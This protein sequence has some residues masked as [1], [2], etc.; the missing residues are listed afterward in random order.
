MEVYLILHVWLN[1][2]VVMVDL[3]VTTTFTGPHGKATTHDEVIHTNKKHPFFTIEYG[4]LPVGKITVGMHMLRA[5][6]QVG[7]VTGW[8]VVP[9]TK[10][11]YN[12]EVQQDHTF[13]VGVGQWVVHNKCGPEDYQKLRDNLA[14]TGRTVDDGQQ[15]HHI[16]PCEFRNH[17]L[18]DAT[19][20]RAGRAFDINAE[21]NDRPLWDYNNR[22]TAAN[23]GE[24][25]HA[26]H[27]AYNQMARGMLNDELTSLQT[28][29]TLS[30]DTA[31]GSLM[32]IIDSLNNYIDL[33][34]AFA[35]I[36]G[37]CAL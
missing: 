3:T 33:A 10:V 1:Q 30:P 32:S 27:Y 22:Y 9:G 4:F 2:A 12:L 31:F 16:I 24:P 11:M 17:G 25:Y 13:T 15:A 7:V 8:K 19:S 21:Y 28:S 36:L 29:G 26:G 37:P 5:D 34:G 18:I 35:N 20:G 14:A 6:G 23:A